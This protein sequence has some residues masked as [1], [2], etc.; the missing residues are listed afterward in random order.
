MFMLPTVTD[1]PNPE[2]FDER[3][4]DS[5]AQRLRLARRAARL[6]QRTVGQR[7]AFAHSQLSRLE[8]GQGKA[9]RWLLR[10][11]SDLYAV[12]FDWLVYGEGETPAELLEP[13]KPKEAP[14]ATPAPPTAP[15]AADFVRQYLVCPV[16]GQDALTP[17]GLLEH[18]TSG[19]CDRVHTDAEAQEL[20]PQATVDPQ[21]WAYVLARYERQ[22]E[23]ARQAARFRIRGRTHW[24]RLVRI[25]RTARDRMLEQGPD[26]F[27]IRN[28]RLDDPYWIPTDLEQPDWPGAI[29]N[30]VSDAELDELE[31]ERDQPEA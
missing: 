2:T 1:R 4:L 31:N 6:D 30:A 11:L 23:A 28:P 15:K 20:A 9:R 29:Q 22:L 3:Q 25:V 24:R 12:P 5:L 17:R 19:R 16:C 14:Q 26:A 18:L 13:Q 8:R 21:P 7:L 27:R 10:S